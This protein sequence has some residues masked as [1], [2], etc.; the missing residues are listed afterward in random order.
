MSTIKK[1]IAE[2]FITAFKAGVDGRAKKNILG[3]IKS[4]IIAEE[5]KKGRTSGD[6]SD[7][8]AIAIIKKSVK[9][10]NEIIDN[11]GDSQKNIDEAK[12]EIEVLKVY[13]PQ[14]MNEEEIDAKIE[15]AIKSGAENIGTI[16]GAFKGLE[17]DK[18][19]VSQK[20]IQKLKNK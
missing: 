5:K 15:E 11:A 3:V 20:A 13:L 4:E 16:M 2:D 10:L 7:E 12:F 18:K 14:Q 9:N 6:V 19:L 8:E 17:V 1:K